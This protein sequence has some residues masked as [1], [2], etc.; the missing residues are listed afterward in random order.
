MKHVFIINSHTTFL[1]ACGVINFLHLDSNDVI[2]LKIR[3]YK[4]PNIA[5]DVSVF[6]VS[7][8]NSEFVS[9]ISKSRDKRQ[10]VIKRLDHYLDEVVND[11][12]VFYAPHYASSFFQAIYTNKRCVEGAFIQEGAIPQKKAFI[13]DSLYKLKV[14]HFFYD[15]LYL[16]TSRLWTTHHW[17][18][19]SFFNKQNRIE[20]FSIDNLFFKYLPSHNNIVTW[21]SIDLGIKISRDSI[22]FVFDGFVCNCMVERDY[23][24]K[25]CEKLIKKNAGL[26][27]YIKFHPAQDASERQLII[28]FFENNNFSHDVL[29]D[30][31]PV[32]LIISSYN[33]LTF[34][35][36][37]SSLLYFAYS[38]HHN[39][40]SENK[41]LLESPLYNSY[42][43]QY[44]VSIF[45]DNL[46][47]FKNLRC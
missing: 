22:I 16:G 41:W 39:V 40:I 47:L 5:L 10:S 26:S 17:Y 20:S 19:K 44:D 1:T 31:I 24:M 32:E 36:F 14:W 3:Q 18:I 6:D 7:S 11:D 34:V 37:S 23:Y 42:L 4:E 43:E 38:Y 46:K 8:I 21:P 27:N 29:D 9:I 13:I 45:E 2:L 25:V 12:F 35:G 33:H 30:S 15:R 28:S